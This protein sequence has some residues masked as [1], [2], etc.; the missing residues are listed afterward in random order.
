MLGE[1][2][3]VPLISA[4]VEF[5]RSVFDSLPDSF[6]M[7]ANHGSSFVEVVH[8][9]SKVSFEGLKLLAAQ[10]LSTNFYRNARE[11][12]YRGIEPR[13]FFETLLLDNSGKIPA[14]VKVHCFRRKAGRPEMYVLHITDRFGQDP[15]DVGRCRTRRADAGGCIAHGRGR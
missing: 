12:H 14:D 15:R 4:P 6:V 11:R 5:T 7:K 8:D 13:L 2:F 10:W 1:A 9:K 3:L